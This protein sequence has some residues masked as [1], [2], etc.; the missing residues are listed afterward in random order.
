MKHRTVLAVEFYHGTPPSKITQYIPISAIMGIAQTKSNRLVIDL[1]FIDDEGQIA[2]H[3]IPLN[4]TTIEAV[5]E[6]YESKVL[7]D[8]L[9]DTYQPNDIKI[10]LN[11]DNR[12]EFGNGSNKE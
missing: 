11:D 3:D 5:L 12:L 2:Y 8:R 6:Q 4:A 7:A 1:P 10:V 9:A